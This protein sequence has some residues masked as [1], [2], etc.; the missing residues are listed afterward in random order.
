MS[1]GLAR[2][3]VRWLWGL[4]GGALLLVL[5]KFFVADV[6]RVDSGSMRPTIFGGRARPDGEDYSERVL[7]LYDRSLE[8]ERFDL[9]VQGGRDGSTPLVKRVCGLPDETVAIRGGDL[10]IDG[11]R[12]PPE[13]PR[14]APIAVFDDRWLEVERFFEFALDGSVRRSGREWL[15]QGTARAPGT[16]LAYHPELRDDYLDRR[17]RR[18]AGLLEVNDAVLELEFLLEPEGAAAKL[19]FALVEEGDTFEAVLARGDGRDQQLSL[20]RRGLRGSEQVL[21]E[22]TAALESGRWYDLRLA[23]IDNHLSLHSER[24]GLALG[25]GYAENEPWSGPA[26]ADQGHLGPRVSFGAEDGRAR[27]R[28]IR[29]LRDLFF[30]DAGTFGV[31]GEV[32]LGEDECFLLGDNSA[33]STDSRHFGPV[34]LRELLGRPLAVV[35]PT[36]RLLAGAEAGP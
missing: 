1:A 2:R 18:V 8:P 35:W 12:L 31:E 29:I 34:R 25:R 5:L 17:H 14:P 32:T 28:S 6:Y 21:L 16:Q 3:A 4:A 33:S 11:E 9:V 36:F 26:A 10:L 27:F 13:V 19:R 7:V 24:L 23:N 30:T 20:V 22:E 15:V